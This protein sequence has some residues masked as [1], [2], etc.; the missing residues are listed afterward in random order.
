M[1]KSNATK[2]AETSKVAKNTK[3][4]L[5]SPYFAYYETVPSKNS[6]DFVTSGLVSTLNKMLDFL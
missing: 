2:A 1:G 6:K 4:S 5:L 3:F